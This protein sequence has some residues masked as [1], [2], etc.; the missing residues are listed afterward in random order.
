[1]KMQVDVEIQPFYIP[2]YVT[3]KHTGNIIA[4]S[5]PSVTTN[6]LDTEVL[7][8]MCDEWRAGVFKLAKK[9]DN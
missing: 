7:S 1:M 9:K 3:L 4:S 6:K 8:K 5:I 2:S